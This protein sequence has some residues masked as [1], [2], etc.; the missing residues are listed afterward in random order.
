MNKTIAACL[1][2]MLVFGGTVQTFAAA[3]EG[4]GG[5]RT[6]LAS[7]LADKSFEPPEDLGAMVQS[8][9]TIDSAFGTEDG[10]PVLYTTSSGTPAV[11]NVVDLRQNKLLRSFPLNGSSS[12]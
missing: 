12:V 2:G 4:D 1:I 9:S 6:R 10:V 3:K 5:G 7:R 8:V 11:F